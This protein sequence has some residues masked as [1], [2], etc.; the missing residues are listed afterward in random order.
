MSNVSLDA[1]F[2]IAL[3]H[4]IQRGVDSKKA[5]GELNAGVYKDIRIELSVLVGEMRV[6]LD[7]DKAPT[8][9]IPWL[10]AMALLIKRMGLQREDALE[11]LRD[12]LTEAIALGNDAAEALAA[13]SGVE[14]AEKRIREEVISKLP[15]TPVK[16]QVTVKD[17]DVQIRSCSA[18]ETQGLER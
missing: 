14:E 13:E 2:A 10:T 9:S 1:K 6:G 15:R 12:V 8:S 5:R 11:T 7:S 3:S 16:G 17:V 4:A 18:A